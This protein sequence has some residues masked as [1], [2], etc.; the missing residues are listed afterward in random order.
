MHQRL[1]NTESYFTTLDLV[2]PW[3]SS[4]QCSP[5]ILLVVA[6]SP[7][8]PAFIT[9]ANEAKTPGKV[10]PLQGRLFSGV[11]FLSN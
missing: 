10:Y 5:D 3:L 9:S 4:Q 2:C 8:F 7:S 6:S 11:V 1:L